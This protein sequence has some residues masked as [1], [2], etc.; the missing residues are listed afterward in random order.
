MRMNN[1]GVV[2]GACLACCL[3]VLA[4]GSRAAG[5]PIYKCL[6]KNLALLYTDEPCKEG[7]Q[8]DIRPG[9]ADPAAV[10]RLERVRDALDQSPSQRIAD[11]R[12]VP[13]EG[14]VAA[15]LQYQPSDDSGSYGYGPAYVSDY[16]I[17]ARPFVRHRGSRAK[18]RIRHF[19]PPPPYFVPRR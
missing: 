1:P 4:P 12:R 6:D 5:T 8:M 15:R 16:G 18:L 3:V 17:V 7:E 10:A 11:L 19:A 2:G 14:S 9:D 13:V